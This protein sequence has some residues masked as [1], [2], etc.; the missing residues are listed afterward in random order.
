M[1]LY[2]PAQYQRQQQPSMRHVQPSAKK[3]RKQCGT[4]MK[5]CKR[6]INSHRNPILTASGIALRCS[7]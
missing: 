3:W 2:L 7:K 6:S 5:P 4:A 1:N